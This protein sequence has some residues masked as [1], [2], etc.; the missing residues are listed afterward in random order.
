VIVSSMPKD[1]KTLDTVTMDAALDTDA[2]DTALYTVAMDAMHVADA[3][4]AIFQHKDCGEIKHTA[5][6]VSCMP[7]GVRR[8][9]MAAVGVRRASRCPWR[10][11][12]LWCLWRLWRP[13]RASVCIRA[14]RHV[15]L[16]TSSTPQHVYV[17]RV[18]AQAPTIC[19]VHAPLST[20]SQWCQAG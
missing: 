7:R 16:S 20:I 14:W 1:K 11:W 9:S 18:H 19:P 4:N 2:T 10:P 15:F 3:R 12:R 8:P 5:V 13:W 17:R 6:E